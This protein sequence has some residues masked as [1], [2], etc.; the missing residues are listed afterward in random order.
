MTIRPTRSRLRRNGRLLTTAATAASAGHGR[1]LLPLALALTL[2]PL[3]LLALPAALLP[4][5]M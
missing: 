5:R 4:L 1:L 3:H 2:L